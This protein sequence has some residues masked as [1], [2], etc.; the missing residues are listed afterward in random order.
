MKYIFFAL[1]IMLS[2][3]REDKGTTINVV[4]DTGLVWQIGVKE[5]EWI[6]DDDGRWVC[7]ANLCH[8]ADKYSIQVIE[9]YTGRTAQNFWSHNR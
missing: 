1:I 5:G 3:C 7:A 4:G 6:V 2:A 9:E 8:P